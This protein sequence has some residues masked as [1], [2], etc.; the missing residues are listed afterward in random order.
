MFSLYGSI[1]K[2]ESLSCNVFIFQCLCVF[3]VLNILMS[4]QSHGIYLKVEHTSKLTTIL[5]FL[6]VFV[7]ACSVRT[8][9]NC[10]CGDGKS[11]NNGQRR[12]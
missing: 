1:L 7:G 10:Y 4:F 11:Q 2:E 8:K 5:F 9:E 12:I 6:I 3:I